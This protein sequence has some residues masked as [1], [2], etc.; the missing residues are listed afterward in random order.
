MFVEFKKSGSQQQGQRLDL[1]I[2]TKP[3]LKP[4][5]NPA[6]FQKCNQKIFV[7]SLKKKFFSLNEKN[8]HFIS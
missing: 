2:K 5:L 7:V 8:K 6:E 3:N 4:L 1:D